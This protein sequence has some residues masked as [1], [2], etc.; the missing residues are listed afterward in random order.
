M[1]DVNKVYENG[2]HAI[3]DLSLDIEDG[4]FDFAP[5]VKMTIA[6][7]LLPASGSIHRELDEEVVPTGV[8]RFEHVLT[9]PA[10]GGHVIA[11]DGRL[12]LAVAQGGSYE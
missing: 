9:I 12:A 7:Y 2:F 10:S 4:E 11:L 8:G 5:R 1:E 6:R 3:H